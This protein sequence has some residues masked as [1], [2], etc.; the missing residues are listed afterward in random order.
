MLVYRTPRA[1]YGKIMEKFQI[2]LT[3][4]QLRELAQN[5]KVAHKRVIPVLLELPVYLDENRRP[6]VKKEDIAIP[7]EFDFLVAFPDMLKTN[8]IVTE[9]KKKGTK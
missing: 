7:A 5:G 1:R 4:L 3:N 8:G 6:Y 2:N 9:P